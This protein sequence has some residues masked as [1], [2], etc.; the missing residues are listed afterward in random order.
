MET[1]MRKNIFLATVALGFAFVSAT[2]QN[3]NPTVEVTNDF[4][5][6]TVDASKPQL[7]MAVPDSLLKFDLEFDY[8]V[9][10]NPYK[11]GYDFSPYLLDMKPAPDAY[12]ARKFYL[13]AGAG[14]TL[15]PEF[16]LV[17]SPELKNK[18]LKINLYAFNRSYIGDYYQIAGELKEGSASAEDYGYELK[19]Y[20]SDSYDGYDVLTKAGMNLRYDWA[21]AYADFNVGYYGLNT[22]SQLSN[23]NYNAA[24]VSGGIHSN[25]DK[26]KYFY[27]DLS[28]DYRYGNDDIKA[29]G[30][31]GDGYTGLAAHDIDA[32]LTL[33]PVLGENNAFLIGAGVGFTSYSKYYNS[34][35][36]H[37]FV[38]PHYV[39]SNERL[40]FSA[41]VKVDITMNSMDD[42]DDPQ[43]N[44]NEGQGI[45][46]DVHFDFRLIP[47]YL[48]FYASATGGVD[49]NSYASM[50][51]SRHFYNLSYVTENNP[52]SKNTIECYNARAG[53]RGN[54]S[55]VFRFDLSGGYVSYEGYLTDD[56]LGFSTQP[57]LYPAVSF[58]D[59]KVLNA[60]LKYV[61]DFSS[62]VMDGSFEANSTDFDEDGASGFE[63]PPFAMDFRA[64]YSWRNRILF[65]VHADAAS[66]RSYAYGESC[67]PGYV[68]LGFDAEYAVNKRFSF[69]FKAD[70]LL[71]QTIQRVPLY[72]EKGIKFTAGICLNL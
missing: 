25:S 46:P 65:A 32:S 50:K 18:P 1:I 12:N 72:A 42:A 6:K 69:W 7:K 13:R 23:S 33:G 38:A 55:S 51:E 15:N 36:G 60:R 8:S 19:K 53:F 29:A 64:R 21:R 2:A 66:K 4:Q 16:D 59:V 3:L 17:W 14:Y 62:F 41:G 11:G 30:T 47:E 70:N 68:N 45:Y 31:F 49:R 43:L 48:D 44:S 40:I 58:N 27:Y 9:F 54:I 5:G 28:F 26:P 57:V 20:S 71:C 67:I 34:Q 63:L 35:V 37:F 10:S 56:V 24:D 61:L 22:K 52:L 39:F